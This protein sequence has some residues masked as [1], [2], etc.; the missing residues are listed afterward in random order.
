MSSSYA[1][2][3]AGWLMGLLLAG[4]RLAALLLQLAMPTQTFEPVLRPLLYAGKLEK[5]KALRVQTWTEFS[6]AVKAG[7]TAGRLAATVVSRTERRTKSGTKMGVVELSDDQLGHLSGRCV[8]LVVKEPE[9]QAQ[10]ISRQGQ[11]A[12]K[13]PAA[14]HTDL[15]ACSRG[16]RFCMTNSVWT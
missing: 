4:L 8:G 15:H 13:L 2:R 16:S 1:P 9:L 11:H 6:R 14:E 7:V 3:A 5:L 10:R 12:P